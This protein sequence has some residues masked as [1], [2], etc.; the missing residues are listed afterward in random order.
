[1][2]RGVGAPYAGL[3][4]P[5]TS[6]ANNIGSAAR[7]V[8]ELLSGFEKLASQGTPARA[9]QEWSPAAMSDF[10]RLYAGRSFAEDPKFQ[11]E[12][13]PMPNLGQGPGT[14]GPSLVEAPVVRADIV[15]P[16]RD[17]MRFAGHANMPSP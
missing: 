13:A 14:G 4:K 3:L 5:F 16:V 17:N 6:L 12:A 11:G 1:M 10:Q 2:A 7:A 15:Q 8:G 9:A